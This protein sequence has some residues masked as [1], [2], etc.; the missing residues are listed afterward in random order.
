MKK[1]KLNK[2][3]VVLFN[4]IMILI[5]FNIVLNIPNIALY[6]LIIIFSYLIIILFI[7]IYII[8]VIK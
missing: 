2:K 3:K 6:N 5:L 7:N 8:E 4:I 1:K